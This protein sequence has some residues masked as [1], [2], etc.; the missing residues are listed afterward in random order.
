MD[1]LNCSSDDLLLLCP[2]LGNSRCR[3]GATVA[4]ADQVRESAWR[5]SS[6][7]ALNVVLFLSCLAGGL[8]V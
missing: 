6:K 1:V 3:C 8:P 5:V 4:R 2:G 7:R